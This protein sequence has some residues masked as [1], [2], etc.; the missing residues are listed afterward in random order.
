MQPLGRRPSP[1]KGRSQGG[2]GAQPSCSLTSPP[3]IRLQGILDLG[4]SNAKDLDRRSFLRDLGSGTI[5]YKTSKCKRFGI[6]DVK[7]RI[8]CVSS[9][10]SG[11][12]TDCEAGLVHGLSYRPGSCT[13]PAVSLFWAVDRNREREGHEAQ[14]AHNPKDFASDCLEYKRLFNLTSLIKDR[15]SVV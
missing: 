13:T 10:A 1:S 4:P 12:S 15:K 2:V 5:E 11:T 3:A 14:T 7:H 6:R 8:F 9:R